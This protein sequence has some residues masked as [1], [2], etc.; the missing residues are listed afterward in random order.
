MIKNIIAFSA[1]IFPFIL[2]VLLVAV[3]FNLTPSDLSEMG[4]ESGFFASVGMI[5]MFLGV[6]LFPITE[7]VVDYIEKLED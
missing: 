7:R 3:E 5:T 2:G 1:I 6:I 4:L